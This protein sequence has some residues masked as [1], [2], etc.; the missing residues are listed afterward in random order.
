MVAVLCMHIVA[1]WF[2]WHCMCVTDT[3]LSV[4][5][6]MLLI[7]VGMSHFCVIVSFLSNGSFQSFFHDARIYF[8][9]DVSHLHSVLSIRFFKLVFQIKKKETS[10]EVET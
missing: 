8:C 9:V 10:M 1:E 3:K 5:A 6:K 4:N 7:L 2:V